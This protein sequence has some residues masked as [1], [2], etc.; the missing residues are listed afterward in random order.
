MAIPGNMLSAA[1]ESMDPTYTGWRPRLNCSLTS[2][3]GGGKGSKTL[4]VKSAAAG[5]WQGAG[6][7]AA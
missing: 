5:E 1:T 6:A 3:T 4:G 2:G 7:R